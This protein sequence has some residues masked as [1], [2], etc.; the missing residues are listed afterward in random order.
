MAAYA[1]M[2]REELTTLRN[3][4]LEE[5]ESFKA[6][7]LKLD[8]SRGKPGADQLDI[9]NDLLTMVTSI[10]ESKIN[11]TDTRNYGG[12]D[13]LPEMKKIFADMLGVDT[14][15]VIVGGN[16]SLNMMY[17]TVARAMLFGIMGSTPWSKLEK[18]K[19]LC[20]VPGYDRHFTICQTFGI[21]MI[22]VEMN[23]D[24]P[25]MDVVEKLVSED[26]AI[27]GIWCVPKYS[28]PGGI[29][30]SDDVVCRF[31][32][33]K[34][35]A[36]DFRIFWDN[37]YVVH[38][39]YD[40]SDPLLNILDEC[41]KAGNEDMCYIFASTSKVTFPGAG[42]AVMAGSASNMEATRK[43]MTFQTIGP[44]KVNQLRHIR[45]LKDLDGVRAHMKKHAAIIRPKFEIVLNTLEK[46]LAGI[47]IAEWH[48]PNGGYFVSLDVYPG[49][50]KKVHA[51]LK[52]AG[53]V[54]TGAG[55]TFPYGNDPKDR[56]LRIAPTFPTVSELEIAVKMLCLCVKLTAV[57]KILEK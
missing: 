14:N 26:S 28:N 10:E 44:D 23:A 50:A 21:E 24:G 2:S 47:G 53:V 33:L 27:K 25:D 18:V 13:G 3:S 8:M 6:Q 32:N 46:E 30:Y 40:V 37:A 43:L 22:P 54:M 17:D 7:G 39:L 42:V 51:L 1:E 15:E 11:G 4:L 36:E 55:A 41:R 31:A 20:P 38:D 5:Y 49:C 12:L 57:E 45:F 52:D 35:A 29:T 19:F 48:K 34:P 16:S 9:S 56:N